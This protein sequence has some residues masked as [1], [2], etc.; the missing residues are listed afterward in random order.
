MI[1]KDKI[2]GHRFNQNF[3]DENIKLEL[4][5]KDFSYIHEFFLKNLTI[6]Y[7]NLI[8]ENDFLAQGVGFEPTF[9]REN[10]FSR[11]AP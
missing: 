2:R 7:I 1:S 8:I 3:L 10:Q 5:F 11:L 4:D 6:Y 9:S